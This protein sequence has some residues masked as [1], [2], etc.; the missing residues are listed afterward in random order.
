MK[1]WQ[2]EHILNKEIENY[3]V[4]SD[5]ILDKK[6]VKYDCIASIAHTK[7][8]KKINILTQEE[9]NK[10][11]QILNEIIKKEDEDCHTA[12]E[13]Y[14]IKKLGDIGKKIHTAR[15]RNDQV[16]TALRLYYKDEIEKIIKNIDLF[17]G[18]LIKF[19]IK[20]GKIQYPG[21]THMKKAMP[22]SFNLWADSFIESMKDNKILIQKILDLIDKLPLGTGSGY[23]LPIKVDQKYTSKILGFKKIHKN[24]IYAQN[25]RG[26]YESLINN[27]L[28][29]IMIDINKISTDILFFNLE[30]LNYIRLSNEI[31]TGSSIMPHKKNP[32]VLE[33]LR[34]NYFLVLS[35]EFQIKSI[36]SNQLS[37]YNRDIQLT[38][39]PI[40]KSFKIVRESLKILR[41]VIKNIKVEKEECKKAMT[42]EL[43]ATKKAYDLVKK[44]ISFR[45][46]YKNVS[47]NF[48]SHI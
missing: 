46:A 31:C 40:I 43:Y 2:K 47:N 29:Q 7:M 28:S 17:I 39:E 15:S 48:N 23:G 41:I 35:N 44:G 21:Y 25:S 38:K 9:C 33:L 8:L 37:G 19:K 42:K 13:N 27:S 18:S 22:S 1:L 5:H 4:G 6:L 20:F 3:T 32:D 12:I 45:D 30:G 11:I 10:I 36:I 16:L 34:A 24:P 14:L 26:K